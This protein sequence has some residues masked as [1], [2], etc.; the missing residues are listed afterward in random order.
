MKQVRLGRTGLRVGQLGF[1][2][3]P[4]QRI[5]RA[6]AIRLI[7]T[8]LDAGVTLLDTARGYSDSEEKIGLA[9]RG[10]RGLAVI[11]TKS[12]ELDAAGMAKA[13]ELS[14]KTLRTDHIDLYQI[15]CLSSWEA[16]Q[17]AISAGGAL[18]ALTRAQREGK[19]RFIGVTSHSIDVLKKII[20]KAPRVFD[21]IQ[22][23]FNFVG[24]E[25]GISLW[26]TARKAGI[27]FLGMKPMCGG[28]L[29]RPDLA[30]R[31][32]LQFEGIVP[33]PG[34][35]TLRELRENIRL[36]REA[37]P[38]DKA[39]ERE[40]LRIRRRM[41]K[42]FCRKCNYCQ[43][44]PQ[45]IAIHLALGAGTLLKRFNRS[46]VSGWC[47]D[48]MRKATTCTKCGLCETRC[49]YKLPIR[50]LLVENIALFRKGLRGMGIAWDQA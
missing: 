30:L 3:I 46:C 28:V 1:G 4:I 31:Y 39:E 29:D 40:L 12:P 13:I 25:S 36:A 42:W 27:G 22:I 20:T 8:A 14:L 10:R 49:P 18:K 24:D 43:P 7:R 33:I 32:V 17:K 45:G 16:F 50:S 23:P 21:T 15:H 38:P 47:R 6:R 5:S 48:I 41:G 19:V 26:P 2:G 44:C 35:E 37:R 9:I 34:M 11:A